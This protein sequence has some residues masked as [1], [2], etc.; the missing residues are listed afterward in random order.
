MLFWGEAIPVKPVF[1]TPQFIPY[2][3]PQGTAP[4]PN[5]LL[6]FGCELDDWGWATC[7]PDNPLQR[8]GC[9]F[10]VDPR[11]LASGLAPDASLVAICKIRTEEHEAAKITGLYLSGC[12][13]RT[14]NQYIFEI[15]GQYILVS[16]LAELQ[17]RFTPIDSSQA[18]LSYAQLATGLDATYS[19]DY[20]P[21]LMYFQESISGTHVIQVGNSFEMNLNNLASCSCEPWFNT[22]VTIRVSRSGQITWGSAVPIYMTTGWSCAD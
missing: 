14:S 11:G 20:D 1:S 19:F 3:T 7:P 6:S 22:Q 4:S 17:Q 5:P 8:F 13:F 18:A 9:D 15:G 2:P 10:L 21:T 12:A 16:S